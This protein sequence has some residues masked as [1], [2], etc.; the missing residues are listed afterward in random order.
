MNKG[1]LLAA[2]MAASLAWCVQTQAQTTTVAGKIPGQFAVSPSGAATYRIPIEVPPGVAGMQPKLEFVYSSQAGNSLLGKGWGL[3]G[4]SAISRCPSTK[5]SDG[6]T[7]GVNLDANDRFC[8]DGQRLILVSGSYGGAGSEYRTERETFSKI[9]FDG[10]AFTVRT[11]DGNTAQYG[12]GNSAIKAQG[13]TT[14]RTWALNKVSDRLG[15]TLTI[16][17]DEDNANGD[18]RPSRI[19]Y[20]GNALVF[21]Y[22]DRTDIVPRYLAGS[23]LKTMKRLSK[24]S[25]SAGATLAKEYRLQYAA[26]ASALEPSH[27]STLTECDGTGQCLPAHSVGWGASGTNSFAAP[28]NKLSAFGT[29]AGWS[30]T[31]AMPRTVMDVNGDGLPDI[32]GFA[33]DGVYVAL[34]TGSGF[35]AP[36]KWVAAFGTSAGGW[37]NNNDMPRHVV[38][39]DG[40]G[41]PDIVGF[42]TDGVYVALNTGSGFATPSKW[43]A[44]FGTQ[45]GGWT[46]NKA[47]P[48]YLIDINGDGLPD[49]VGFDASG[50]SVALNTG[51]S[52]A[53]PSYAISGQFGTAQGWLDNEATPRYLVDVNGDGLPDVVGFSL[54]GVLVALNSPSGFVVP[55]YS[56]GGNT[57]SGFGCASNYAP[58]PYWSCSWGN[59]YEGVDGWSCWTGSNNYHP[60]TLAGYMCSSGGV[61]YGGTCLRIAT[62]QA[63]FSC[64]ASTAPGGNACVSSGGGP[65]T[66]QLPAF[67]LTQGFDGSK[68]L[69]R[70]L[71]DVN[72]DGLPDIVGFGVAGVQVGLNTGAGFVAP[73]QWVAGFGTAS[74]WADS[75]SFPRRLVDINGDGSPDIVGFGPNGVMVALN[76]GTAF[77]ASTQWV[78]AYG[79]SAGGW[80]SNTVMPRELIDVDGDGLP[81]VVGFSAAAV[82][83]SANARG[84]QA[85]FA[86]RFDNGMG[87]VHT[88]RYAALTS[89]ADVGLYTK[90]SGATQ[91]TLPWVDLHG[92]W[93]VVAT[94]NS[95]NGLGG[96]QS[97]SY[98]YGGLKAEL[99]SG[100]GMLG[101]R[102]SSS[103]D[104]TTSVEQYTEYRQDWPY[105]GM[106]AKAETRL[107]GAG[108]SGVLQ[109]S[110]AT[111]GCK[112]PLNGSAC[113][114]VSRCDQASNADA[115]AAAAN[116]RYFPF[117][118]SLRDERWDLNGNAYPIITNEVEYAFNQGDGKFYGE[119]SKV[120]VSTSDG[121]SRTTSNEYYPAD[122]TNW[123]FGRLKRANV[124]SVAPDAAA[125]AS[126]VPTSSTPSSTAPS[127]PVSNPSPT[128][129]SMAWLM[130]IITQ[131]LD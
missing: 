123:I 76:T 72:G 20:A 112:I 80:S 27:L 85:H 56:C 57:L 120:T 60:A 94:L 30:D 108:N 87:R 51:T 102:W 121:Y 43:V 63:S 10:S 41:L 45:A 119:A 107:A 96:Q 24:V 52:F 116:I 126:S 113:Q 1:R 98:R 92:S 17:Y 8:L 125:G 97:K 16:D 3:A 131:L 40:D 22:A 86:T 47:M 5:A 67:G 100:R 12:V 127:T 95:S 35:A 25:A 110:T 38:D 11:K 117:V 84:T 122:A 26:Q 19:D 33:A 130:P 13:K 31:V 71:A 93:Y 9:S 118:A 54:V 106:L 34:N 49:V 21:E 4:L 78:G 65:T 39:V 6:A 15:N 77:D 23:V 79:T 14:V 48:R 128:A 42:G 109:R 68:P 101:F 105:T 104:S 91:A 61:S 99:G 2:A 64:P 58:Q 83:V 50:M 28:A 59:L 37:T 124:V 111:L 62:T 7:G 36:S 82:M 90:D 55:S 129:A 70:Y 74:G 115:C 75:D 32:V 46:N 44:A 29:N 18:Y 73:S 114:I 88:P 66:W 103:T 81:D 53:P 89:P 69:P